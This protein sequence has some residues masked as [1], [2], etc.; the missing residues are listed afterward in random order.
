MYKLPDFSSIDFRSIDF[1]KLDLS[2]LDLSKL[3]LSKFDLAALRN[4][5]VSK[6]VPSVDFSTVEAGKF[7]AALRDAAYITVGLGVVAVEQVQAR[8][9]QLVEA[10][11]IRFG[12]SKT[13]VETLL[14][15][16]EARM[17]KMDEQVDAVE[18]RVDM[19]VDRLEG[20]LPEQAG[21]LF[22]HARDL[23]KGARKQVR[24]LIRT[25]A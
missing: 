14:G 22:G 2:K 10:I 20:V 9:R 3:D 15:T 7:T 5:D 23:T 13:H 1:S 25:A 21:V 12:A 8:R 17:A 18:A 24:G 11:S 16:F 4:I 19:I 6:Y